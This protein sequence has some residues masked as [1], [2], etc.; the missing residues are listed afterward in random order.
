[1]KKVAVV[2]SGCGVYDGTE[3]Q[4]VVLT[5]LALSRRGYQA[6]CCAPAIDFD[7]VNH[8]SQTSYGQQRNCIE[9]SARIARGD[10]MVLSDVVCEEIDAAIYPGG[11]GVAKNISN[12]ATQGEACSVNSDVVAFGQSLAKLQKPQGFL[13]IAPVLMPAIYGP[14]VILT[15]GNDQLTARQLESM[16]ANHVNCCVNEA[17]VDQENRAISSPAYML[18]Q[19]ITEVEASVEA[20]VNAMEPWLNDDPSSKK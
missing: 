9:E 18:A 19:T 4:E 3:I 17:V 11:F 13:C 15:V 12:F 8:I 6:I 2:L 1:M 7:V 20:L 14:K 5:L 10:I 16:G